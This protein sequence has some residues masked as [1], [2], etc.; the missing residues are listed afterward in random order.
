MSAEE[1]FNVKRKLEAL[2]TG[3]GEGQKNV[4]SHNRWV[5]II[6]TSNYYHAEA[7]LKK[8]IP[9]VLHRAMGGIY[10]R[11]AKMK[12]PG[13]NKFK[14][15]REA[16]GSIPTIRSTADLD[17]EAAGKLREAREEAGWDVADYT[18]GYKD[19]IIEE[20]SVR[21]AKG[22]GIGLVALVLG[23]VALGWLLLIG[24]I[25]K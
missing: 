25:R 17:V 1:Y 13:D 19:P 4:L 12:A 11:A 16:F 2:N 15:Y 9:N 8:D 14:T 22:A 21:R 23:F 5:L 3:Y 20:T 7:R 10:F 18:R 6:E 24:D